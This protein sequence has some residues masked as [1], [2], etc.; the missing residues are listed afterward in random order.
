[1]Y[2][3]NGLSA[4]LKGGLGNQLFQFSALYSISRTFGLP[5]SLEAN[6]GFYFDFKHKRE[7]S[8]SYLDLP[9]SRFNSPLQSL[10]LASAIA[11]NRFSWSSRLARVLHLPR[12]YGD[13][14]IPSLLNCHGDLFSSY[15]FFDGY[16][17]DYRFVLP[18]EDEIRTICRPPRPIQPHILSMGRQ[19]RSQQSVAICLRLY[20]ECDPKNNSLDGRIKTTGEINSAIFSLLQRL[21][22]DT[23]LYVF[24]THEYPILRDL[25]LPDN[26]TLITHDNGFAG[27]LERLWLMTQCQHFIMLNSSFYWWAAF[28]S[29][30]LDP[31][32]S[33]ERYV[34]ASDNFVFPQVIPPGWILY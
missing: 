15:S 21:A 24:I 10:L 19:M 32:A 11:Y 2:F 34:Y 14:D 22:S 29:A 31:S 16:F 6:L 30:G 9:S 1:M 27:T 25:D 13:Q 18:Y 33:S 8:L 4:L 26:S 17:Q 5:Y 12:I 28:L 23:H 7:F 3:N 20:E